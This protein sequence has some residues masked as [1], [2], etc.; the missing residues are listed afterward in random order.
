MHYA[1][2]TLSIMKCAVMYFS[3]EGRNQE[4]KEKYNINEY[5]RL[6]V[7]IM[8]V[9][10]LLFFLTCIDFKDNLLKQ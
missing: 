7:L 3:N 8:N 4:I 9:F 2:S 1:L 5:V 10:V 6:F